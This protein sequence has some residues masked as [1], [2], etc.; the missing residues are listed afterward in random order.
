M[1]AGSMPN[2]SA[3]RLIGEIGSSSLR[4]GKRS[5]TLPTRGGGRSLEPLRV[6]LATSWLTVLVETIAPFD[7]TR[8]S[9]TSPYA[10]T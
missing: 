3:I 10:A 1:S 5:L 9:E 2:L 8:L 6:P 7:E 4:I